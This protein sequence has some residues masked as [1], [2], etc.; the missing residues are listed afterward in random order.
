MRKSLGCD[1]PTWLVLWGERKRQRKVES[2]TIKGSAV[3]RWYRVDGMDSHLTTGPC[4]WNLEVKKN[5]KVNVKR[6]KGRV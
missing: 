6:A 1:R 4:E 2:V 3:C 5:L